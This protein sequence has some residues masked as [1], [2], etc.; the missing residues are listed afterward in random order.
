[1]KDGSAITS[2]FVAH[3][4]LWKQVQ[5]LKP[6]N[7]NTSQNTT[8]FGGRNSTHFDSS[9]KEIVALFEPNSHIHGQMDTILIPIFTTAI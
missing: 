1:M 8:V 3:Y 5:L 9:N 6:K 7:K 2:E 4:W